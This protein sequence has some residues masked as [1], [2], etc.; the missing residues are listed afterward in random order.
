LATGANVTGA[1]L[2]YIAERGK[3]AV[4]LPAGART[5]SLGRG[6]GGGPG[7]PLQIVFSSDGSRVGELLVE[8]F[9]EAVGQR[10][11]TIARVVEAAA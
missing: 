1:G 3:E 11:G 7:R 8:L 9:R 2:A 5:E 4:Y 6:D 10:G